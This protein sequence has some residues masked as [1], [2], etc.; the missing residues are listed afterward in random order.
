LLEMSGYGAYEAK[1]F[2]PHI[3]RER[4]LNRTILNCAAFKVY[5]RSSISEKTISGE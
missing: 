3:S 4:T 1:E 2:Y 5:F